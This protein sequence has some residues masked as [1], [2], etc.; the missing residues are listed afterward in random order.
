MASDILVVDDESDIR[1]LIAEILR[2]E[3][4]RCR[5]ADSSE[6]ALDAFES[7]IPD[8]IILDIW[9]QG[10]GMDGLALLEE[11]KSKSPDLPVIMISGHADIVG[12]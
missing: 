4:F 5:E 2:D 9:L 10:S 8:L 7:R 12:K 3:G 6:T 1:H 11:I